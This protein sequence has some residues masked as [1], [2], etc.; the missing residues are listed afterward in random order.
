VNIHQ[1]A[2]LT[3]CGRALLVQRLEA[4]EKPAR[5]AAALGISV[6]T[7]YKW[8]SRWR[9]EGE[10]GLQDRSSRPHR[11]PNR[12]AEEKVQ[13]IERLRRCRYSSPRIARELGLCLATVVVVVRRLGLARLSALEPPR[14]VV[15][16]ERARPGE[17]LHLD[18]K[19]LG[20]IA[21][22]GHRIHG[23][24]TTRVRGIGWEY[25]HV[26]VDDATRLA[27]T[28][29]LKDEKQE[30]CTEFLERA[31]AWFGAQ[32]I[33]IERV[34]TDN[35]S[36]YRAKHFRRSLEAIGARQ[37]R[38]RPYTPRTNGKAERFIQ[39]CLREWAYAEAYSSSEQRTD[40]LGRFQRY[41][42]RERPHLGIR[43]RSPQQRYRELAVNNVLVNDS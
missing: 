12:L 42:N 38:T 6:R 19:K 3:P 25:L 29:M 21:R 24:R 17:L 16:Y 35:G 2:R 36:G 40:A 30:R 39:T 33:G 43:G 27:Y 18:T 7:A 13:A 5:V 37:I 8:H 26:A 1:H 32:G 41:Y 14:P 31:C 10:A 9:A 4:G 34:M 11:S 22:V 28:E 23:D 15:R 20:S